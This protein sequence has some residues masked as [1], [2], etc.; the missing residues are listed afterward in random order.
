[1]H[2]GYGSYPQGPHSIDLIYIQ[3]FRSII[4]IYWA[5]NCAI[6]CAQ[7]SAQVFVYRLHAIKLLKNK[8]CQTFSIYLISNPKNYNYNWN[9]WL[10]SSEYCI[11][12]VTWVPVCRMNTGLCSRVMT[13]EQVNPG[14]SLGEAGLVTWIYQSGTC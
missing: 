7:F 11:G 14:P 6:N 8:E 9:P 2:T 10:V 12:L 3:Y 1:M 13:P 5:L 4:C